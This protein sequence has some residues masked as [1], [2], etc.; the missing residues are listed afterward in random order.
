MAL[1]VKISA[2]AARQIQAATVW[3]NDNRP[4]APGAVAADFAQAVALL[5][6][7]PGLGAAYQGSRTPGLRRLF[8][9]R[10]GYFVYY[11]QHGNDLQVLAFWHSSRD[12]QPKL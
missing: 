10:V 8:L 12:L 4:S 3:W 7:Q 1:R 5:V 9:N 2:R 11:R 6:V